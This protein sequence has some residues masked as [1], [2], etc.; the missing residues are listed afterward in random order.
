[1][2]EKVPDSIPLGIRDDLVTYLFCT[3]PDRARLIA[4][5]TARNPGLAGL[6]MD[7]EANDDLRA[8]LEIE[9]LTA[10]DSEASRT[11]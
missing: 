2:S 3:S 7:L 4:E 6:L 10:R 8:R 1:M 11:S 9:L 5:M